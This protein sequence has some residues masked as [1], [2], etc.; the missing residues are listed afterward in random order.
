MSPILTIAVPCYNVERYLD[1]GLSSYCDDRFRG[2]LEVILVNDG[3]TDSTAALL[4]KYRQEQPGI[5]KII[6]K[7][8][9]GHG[10]AVNAAL[11]QAQGTYFRIVDGDDWVNPD[12]LAKVLEAMKALDS[13]LVVDLKREVHLQ[14]GGT[15]LF[16][17][18]DA[19][20][21]NSI[22]PFSEVCLIDGAESYIMIHTLSAR[23]SLLRDARVHLLEKT[24]YEDYEYVIKATV[25]AKTIAFLPEEVYQYLVGNVAQSVSAENYVK[26]WDDHVRVLQEIVRYA[27]EV[28]DPSAVCSNARS[29]L[30]LKIDLM[31][32]T[33]YNI[34]LIY[35]AD[36]KRGAARCKRLRTW[37][38]EN[39][40]RCAK[41]TAKRY[42]QA[43]ALHVLGFD[44][45]KLDRLM[46]R[47]LER[48]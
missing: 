5:F 18:P 30:D 41:A 27:S 29:Y 32:N 45:R 25:P 7:E 28:V 11:A 16:S 3:S 12:G 39:C 34:A 43:Y 2:L 19:L 47:R 13:D 21:L 22:V 1:H 10:S 31:V 24:F 44:S 9:G 36:R 38:S 42:R 20:P 48:A 23:T 17:L 4:E 35:D 37:L 8:N 6:T 33:L 46:G 15:Q 14:T 26:R 40:P